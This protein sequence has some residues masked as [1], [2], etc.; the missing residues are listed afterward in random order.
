MDRLLKVATPFAAVL[1]VVV[2][3]SAPALG[4]ASIA[5]VIGI[6]ATATVA[7]AAD[8]RVTVIGGL[9]VSPVVVSEGCDVKVR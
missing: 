9:I 5:R 8:R 2:P 4:F 1:T 7:P 3:D 6:P